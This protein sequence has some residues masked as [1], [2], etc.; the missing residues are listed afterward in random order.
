MNKVD[1]AQYVPTRSLADWSSPKGTLVTRH[2]EE[3]RDTLAK[4]R[5]LQ[6]PV[7]VER[8]IE[9][10]HVR[11]DHTGKSRATGA[12]LKADGEPLHFTHEGLCS[13][14]NDATPG[15]WTYGTI[16][17]LIDAHR[18]KGSK[19]A[20]MNLALLMRG[21]DRI[22]KF[23]TVR[24]QDRG[25]VVRSI[26]AVV[27]KGYAT[28]DNLEF[29]ESILASKDMRD[30]PVLS[31]N[32][33]SSLMRVRFALNPLDQIETNKPIP[34]VE[35]WNSEVARRSY[36]FAWG[37]WK[38]ICTNG[39]T[40]FQRNQE[41]KWRHVGDSAK[42]AGRIDNAIDEMKLRTSGMLQE[43]NHALD[44]EIDDAYAWIEETL[45]GMLNAEQVIRAQEALKHET[46]T[47]GGLLASAVD[48]VTYAAQNEWDLAAQAEMERAG[49]YLMRAGLTAAV[50]KQIRV[51]A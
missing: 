19:L 1:F 17:A 11:F 5:A 51:A 6:E 36:G 16:Q 28:F 43:Y 48:A 15:Y 2:L 42:F 26:R 40:S 7:D 12:F 18:E 23:R 33:S 38:L 24:T 46:T 21:D 8:S 37:M 3:V 44:I 32:E 31:Y 9:S 27:S 39:M 14:I 50:D 25:Q 4:R 30:L 47:P 45:G 29:I 20:T 34:M 35:A 22:R 49:H 13:L 41:F 10:L